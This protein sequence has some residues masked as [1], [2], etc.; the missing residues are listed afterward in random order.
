MLSTSTTRKDFNPDIIRDPISDARRY[1]NNARDTLRDNGKL[2]T[3]TGLYEDSKYVKAAGNYLWSGVLIA[4]DAVFHV[5]KEKKNKKGDNSRI[6]FDDYIAVIT[7]RDK[8]LLS[9][10]TNG[11][12]IMHLYMTYDGIQD[13]NTCASGF[14]L[15]NEIIDWCEKALGKPTDQTTGEQIN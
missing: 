7:K 11:Y 9:L 8:K 13:K 5:K 3:K 2:N 6:D 1:V 4:L 12:Q 15:A 14:R 10:A